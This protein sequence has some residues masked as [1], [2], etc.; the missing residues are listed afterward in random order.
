M[1]R[2]T[3][4]LSRQIRSN[5]TSPPLPNRSVNC[6]P[7]SVSTSSGIPKRRS[8][9]AN[10]R[11]TARPVARRTTVAITQNRE[12]SSTPVT[13]L[14]SVPSASS[15]P[16]TMSICHSCIGSVPLPA[17]VVLAAAG[18]RRRGRSGR[19]GPGS[20]TPSSATAP[21]RDTRAGPARAPS[22]ADPTADAPGAAHT[23]P[24]PPPATPDAD[25]TSGPLGPVRNPARPVVAHSGPARCARSAA[26]PRTWA[27]T[28]V[29]GSPGPHR[30]DGPIPLLHNGHV[31]Q[32]QSR[33]PDHASP[34][35]DTRSSK[36]NTA[37]CQA[38]GGTATVKH[39]PGQDSTLPAVPLVRTFYTSSRRPAAAAARRSGPRRALP[40]R[41][42]RAGPGSARPTA[43]TTMPSATH[44]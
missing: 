44:Q 8:A 32:R 5:S 28:S 16:P 21:A 37:P 38:S 18:A 19:A 33:P 6:L 9:A 3:M 2:W 42:R 36:P 1:S 30:Q 20:G 34:A 27:A 17:Q 14:A 22:A 41:S 24:P 13:T 15:T 11:H 23:P 26:T 29:T 39:Q 7:L 12:W 43:H 35:N 4:P 31:H 40:L 25:T 10:A